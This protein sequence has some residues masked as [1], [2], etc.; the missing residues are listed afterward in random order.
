MATSGRRA[1][2][3]LSRRRRELFVLGGSRLRWGV[4]WFAHRSLL[5]VWMLA[6]IAGGDCAML[7]DARV[8]RCVVQLSMRRRRVGVGAVRDRWLFG[9]WARRAPPHARRAVVAS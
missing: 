6:A 4:E 7:E 3:S 5:C 2:R 8:D 1:R 9:G